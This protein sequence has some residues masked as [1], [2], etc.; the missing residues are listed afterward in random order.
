[1]NLHSYPPNIKRIALSHIWINSSTGSYSWKLLVVIL[2]G[3]HFL[4]LTFYRS[5]DLRTCY[6]QKCVNAQTNLS[7]KI[8]N[9]TCADSILNWCIEKQIDLSKC[10]W[11]I[12]T[13]RSHFY[14]MAA[15]IN[16]VYPDRMNNYSGLALIRLGDGEMKLMFGI[17]VQSVDPWSWRGGQSRLGRDLRKALSYPKYQYNAFSP[18][19]HGVYDAKSICS[20]HELLTM[21]YQHPKY[22]TYTNLFVNSNYPSTKLLHQSLI[23]DYRKKIIL[24]INNETSPKKLLELN[25]WACEILRYP[26]NGPLL[27]ESNDFRDQAINKIVSAAERYRNRLFAF[28]VGPLSR[29][30]IYHAWLRNPYNRYIDFGSTLDEMIKDR[31]TRPYQSNSQINRDPTYVVKFDKSKHLFQISAQN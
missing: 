14:N 20:F 10:S 13:F 27:W 22:L 2:L 4:S 30:L 19:Y 3:F 5:S 24:V 17:S 1:M 12:G 21:I 11:T 23:Q 8:F 25:E 26:N 7:L 18:F 9:V 16:P 31:V 29:I 6:T 28:S 15:L